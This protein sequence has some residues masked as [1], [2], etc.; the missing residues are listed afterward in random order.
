MW[1]SSP[2]PKYATESSG[3]WFAS[4]SSIRSREVL[5][6][7]RAQ[8]AC[9]N[10]WV[11]GRFSQLVP[12]RSY[13]YGIASSRSPSTPISSQKSIVRMIASRTFGFSKLRSGWC[14]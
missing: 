14:E 1:H 11:S 10:A 8:L 6:D 3:H 4:A 2:S 12:S 5:V 7:V 9:R 13:R